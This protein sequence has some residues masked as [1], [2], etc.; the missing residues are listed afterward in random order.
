MCS[1]SASR[2]AD[3]TTGKHFSFAGPCAQRCPAIIHQLT[4]EHYRKQKPIRH[5]LSAVGSER[6]SLIATL[7]LDCQIYLPGEARRRRKNAPPHVAVAHS[8]SI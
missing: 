8:T 5:N 1:E 2:S 3:A 4:E 6:P 7:D